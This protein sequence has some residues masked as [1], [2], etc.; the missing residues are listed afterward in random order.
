MRTKIIGALVFITIMPVT[1]FV[2]LL[3]SVFVGSNI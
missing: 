3:T 2:L 1:P